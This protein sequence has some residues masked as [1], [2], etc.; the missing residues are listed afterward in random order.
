VPEVRLHIWKVTSGGNGR[1]TKSRSSLPNA[2]SPA[3]G[4]RSRIG[5]P[6]SAVVSLGRIQGGIDFG[7]DTREGEQAPDFS[8]QSLGLLAEVR[9]PASSS[10]G[11]AHLRES[12]RPGQELRFSL[13]RMILQ[14]PIEREQM[15]KLLAPDAPT[16]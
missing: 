11:M 6:F 14:Q 10:T 7:Q 8:G 16:C 5:K 1:P 13:G 4:F 3:H 9:R 15:K 2:R 12:S